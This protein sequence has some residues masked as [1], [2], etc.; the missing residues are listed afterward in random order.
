MKI[1]TRLVISLLLMVFLPVLCIFLMIGVLGRLK[2]E[3]LE[4]MYGVDASADYFVNSLQAI[5]E[6]T[7]SIVSSMREEAAK[8]PDQ[9]LN[10][11]FLQDYNTELQERMLSCAGKE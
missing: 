9:F 11:A 3:S 7:D 4:K 1:K 5:S 10:F 8:N 2:L 6:T